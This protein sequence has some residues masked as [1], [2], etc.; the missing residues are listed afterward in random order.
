MKPIAASAEIGRYRFS[1]RTASSVPSAWAVASASHL[2]SPVRSK[3]SIRHRT[4]HVGRFQLSA[5][6]T[7]ASRRSA[8][9]EGVFARKESARFAGP[10]LTKPVPTTRAVPANGSTISLSASITSGA[11]SCDVADANRAQTDGASGAFEVSARRVILDMRVCA[12]PLRSGT[13]AITTASAACAS[14]VCCTSGAANSRSGRSS[15]C[16]SWTQW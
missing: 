2:L 13:R 16:L 3:R 1:S 7:A 12:S 10:M 11:V 14:I 8:R 4:D 6:A 15:A 5:S 9:S